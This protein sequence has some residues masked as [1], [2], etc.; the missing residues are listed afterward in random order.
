MSSIEELRIFEY[1]ET[2]L[3]RTKAEF[4]GIIHEITTIITL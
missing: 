1:K 4:N 3:E 2:D